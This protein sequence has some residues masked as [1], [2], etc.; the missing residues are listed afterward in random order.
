MNTLGIVLVVVVGLV[1]LFLAM[2][3]KV[4]KQYEQGDTS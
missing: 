1:L 2:A 4:V 3:F